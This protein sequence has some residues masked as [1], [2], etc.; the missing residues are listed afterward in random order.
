[1]SSIIQSNDQQH[2]TRLRDERETVEKFYSAFSEQNLNLVDAVLAPDWSDIPLAPGQVAGPEGIKTIISNMA[3]ALPD[4]KVT[5]HEMVQE[6]GK[7]GVRAEMSGTHRGVLFGIPATGKQVSIRLYDFHTI[8]NGR[9]TT[10]WHME[11]WL[12]LFLQLGQFPA[13]V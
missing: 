10:T 2:A 7:I 13:Q 8:K 9:L 4:L 12:G 11:D 5:I 1:M 6:P 3:T